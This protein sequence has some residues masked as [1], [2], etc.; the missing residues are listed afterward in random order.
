MKK[1][2]FGKLRLMSGW[3]TDLRRHYRVLGG[4]VPEDILQCKLRMH[5]IGVGKAMLLHMFFHSKLSISVHAESN[6]KS[7]IIR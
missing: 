6:H 1:G 4:P 2:I 3:K 7:I 5:R